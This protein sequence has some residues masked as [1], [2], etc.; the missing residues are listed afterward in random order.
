[1]INESTQ[2]AL[3]RLLAP[4][5]LP[6]LL[7]THGSIWEIKE[8][9]HRNKGFKRFALI[10]A[11]R[12]WFQRYGSWI[13][14][15]ATFHGPPHFPHG[16]YGV[17]ISGDAVIGKNCIMYPNVTIG[18]NVLYNSSHKGAPTIGDNC[19][20]GSSAVLHS[21]IIIGDHCTIGANCS[22]AQ[23]IPSHSM[24]VTP[25]AI[26]VEGVNSNKYHKRRGGVWRYY[27]DGKWTPETDEEILALLNKRKT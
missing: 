13:S 17:F 22:I 9:I 8:T 7:K 24:T 19:I 20:V 4:L 14:F 27:D 18:A 2:I 21:N 26:I 23:N 1:M 10:E 11:Y 5:L 16:P 3:S 15:N 12:R 6:V 25:K